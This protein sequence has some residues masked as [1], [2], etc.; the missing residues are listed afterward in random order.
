[1][2]SALILARKEGLDHD[3]RESFA[4]AGI[5]HLLAIFGL[6]VGV[7]SMLVSMVVRQ[8]GLGPRRT[9]MLS[10]AVTWLYVGFIGF[11]DAATRAALILTFVSVSRW[12]TR[13]PG[14][15][16]AVA[17]SLLVL[18]LVDPL[19]PARPGF[20]LSFAGALGLLIVAPPIRRRLDAA[21]LC[22][23]PRPFKGG[24]A[25][26]VGATLATAPIVAWHFGRVSLVG[27]PATL[28]AAP[29]VTVAI[30]GLLLTLAVSLIAPGLAQLL[31]GGTNL[32]LRAL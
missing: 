7:V 20:Q 6:H 21:W 9:G 14:A 23:I 8:I 22:R 3:V 16:G 30:P 24:L 13:P 31:A 32:S 11:P 27:L 17:T 19:S 28:L 5:A 12:R 10:S 1:M 25:A 29:L 15:L 26:G 18:F 2:A 4:I